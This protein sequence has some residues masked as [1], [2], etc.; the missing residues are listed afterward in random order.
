MSEV[1]LE[2]INRGNRYTKYIPNRP[3][4]KQARFLSLNCLEAGYGGAAGGGKSDALLSD[5]LEYVHIPGYS[6]ILF[7][8]TYKDLALPGALMDRAH[9]W[10]ADTDAH[11]DGDNKTY[12][13]PA[14]AS[15]TFGYLDSPN[16]KYRYQGSAYQFAGF[17]EG[18]QFRE[19]DYLYI[20]SRLRRLKGVNIPLRMRMATN[21][22]GIGH[23]WVKARFIDNPGD[24]IFVPAKL[25][26]NPH[27]DKETYEMALNQLDEVTRRQLRDGEWLEDTSGHVYKYDETINAVDELPYVPGQSQYRY[28]LGIDYGFN[29]ATSFAVHA[30][31]DYHS[32]N[33]YIVKADKFSGLT[34]SDAAD[35][36][37]EAESRYRFERIVGDLGGLGKGYGE[38]LKQRYGIPIQAAQKNNKAG[39]IKIMNGDFERGTIKIVRP[40]CK[41]LIEEYAH[42]L[43]KD[44][45]R[46]EEHPGCENHAAD[47]ALYGYREVRAWLHKEKP[48]PPRQGTKEY[49]E[50]IDKQ[51]QQQLM[52]QIHRPRRSGLI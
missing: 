11:W 30:Y 35:Y 34:P 23:K 28:V 42:L 12:R 44:G 20:F 39:Y 6:A 26:D 2:L 29:D 15:L 33:S 32:K 37:K 25:D 36:V 43:W 16:D 3:T 5:A 21:P 38:E 49:Y 52:N 7:R 1:L 46:L 10:L 18:T 14:G 51:T 41:P 48:P 50:M 9:Q 17:D 19:E 13:F 40:F 27:L 24:R 45:N 47:A 22:G 8:K 31:N 4:E